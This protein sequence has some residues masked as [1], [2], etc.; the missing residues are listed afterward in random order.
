MIRARETPD[1]TQR[2]LEN[3]GPFGLLPFFELGTR[4]NLKPLGW[5]ELPQGTR[6]LRYGRED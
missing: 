3:F 2:A 5:E 1:L 4:L 6:L